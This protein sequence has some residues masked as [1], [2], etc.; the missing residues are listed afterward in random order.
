MKHWFIAS[1]PFPAHQR[2]LLIIRAHHT[3]VSAEPSARWH[4]HYEKVVGPSH[5]SGKNQEDYLLKAKDAEKK[6]R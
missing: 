2:A 5:N 1:K 3:L 4:A 6:R